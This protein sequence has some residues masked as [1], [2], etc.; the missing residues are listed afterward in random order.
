MC[1]C[2]YIRTYTQASRRR[3]ASSV[4]RYAPPRVYARVT[5]CEAVVLSEGTVRTDIHTH[6]HT[7]RDTRRKDVLFILHGVS[8]SARE[9]FSSRSVCA[10]RESVRGIRAR[11]SERERNSR[12]WTWSWASFVSAPGYI[13]VLRARAGDG[14]R[15]LSLC[16]R[17]YVMGDRRG[18]L[19]TRRRGR[20]LLSFIGFSG[21]M[22]I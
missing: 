2:V 16:L 10:G 12:A 8:K 20:K 9:S 17:M 6:I 22:Y 14:E 21:K 19:C 4:R 18:V 5:R 3:K 7:R 15:R 13:L 11:V 1:V